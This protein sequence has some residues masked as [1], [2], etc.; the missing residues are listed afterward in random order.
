MTAQ[1]ELDGRQ[2][3]AMTVRE[4]IRSALREELE[5]DEDV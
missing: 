2:T 3:E 5:R 4:A 1:A